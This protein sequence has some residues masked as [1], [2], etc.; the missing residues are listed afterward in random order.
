M[1]DLDQYYRGNDVK[2]PMLLSTSLQA[3]AHIT[4]ELVNKLLILAKGAGVPLVENPVT[5]SI[6]NSGWRPASINALVPNAALNSLHITCEACDLHDPEGLLDEWCY[7][8]SE[9]ILKDLGLWLEHPAS[10]RRWCHVQTKPP[11]SGR[12]VFYP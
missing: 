1:I 12:R 11:K 10:T 8:V 2:F 9:T 7:T 3:K 5:G 6:V 4:V